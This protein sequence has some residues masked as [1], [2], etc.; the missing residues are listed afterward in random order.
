MTQIS[1]YQIPGGFDDL[2]MF[3]CRLS[4]KAWR[5]NIDVLIYSPDPGVVAA[6]DARL[7]DYSATS[8]LAHDAPTPSVTPQISL[9]PTMIG[10]STTADQDP[11]S[12]RGLLINLD[13]VAPNW[14]GRFD[15]LAEIV[16]DNVAAR[17]AKRQRY[18]YYRDRGYPLAYHDLTHNPAEH[19]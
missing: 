11:G 6:L 3:T 5:R 2:L 1:F 8:F 19:R 16:P 9:E 14:F 7:W 4:E 18:R 17:D 10:I 15:R 13:T 12:C